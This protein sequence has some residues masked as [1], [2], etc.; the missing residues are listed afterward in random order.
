MQTVLTLVV[1]TVKLTLV[2]PAATVTM[3]GKVTADRKQGACSRTLQTT[4]QR[5]AGS[6][7]L[8]SKLINKHV[9]RTLLPHPQDLTTPACALN[10]AFTVR[11]D[12][13]EKS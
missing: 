2:L 11:N 12:S 5:T 6:S 4:L 7:P 13:S 8:V 9:E 3:L 10:S 1:L